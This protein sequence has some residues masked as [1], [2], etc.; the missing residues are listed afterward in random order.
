MRLDGLEHLPGAQ[1]HGASP[2]AGSPSCAGPSYAGTLFLTLGISSCSERSRCLADRFKA[3][4]PFPERE[5]RRS[6][7]TEKRARGPPL[8]P[9]W[10]LVPLRWAAVRF[11]SVWTC[12]DRRGQ[13]MATWF[14]KVREARP[15]RAAGSGLLWGRGGCASLPTGLSSLA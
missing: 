8:D 9:H 10:M 7:E 6:E 5:G 12:G 1:P 2:T 15:A 14:Q 13:R 3:F 11:C 4:K